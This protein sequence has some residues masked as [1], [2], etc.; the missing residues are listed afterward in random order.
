MNLMRNP[1]R[2]LGRGQPQLMRQ[3]WLHRTLQQRH[4]AGEGKGVASNQSEPTESGETA[5]DD[6]T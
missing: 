2:R 5:P 6:Q 3:Y 1:S 4:Y